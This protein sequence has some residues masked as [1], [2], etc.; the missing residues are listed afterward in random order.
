MK[1]SFEFLWPWFAFKSSASDMK[2]YA[3]GFPT[4]VEYLKHKPSGEWH[5]EVQILGFGF[6][7]ER[8]PTPPKKDV[9]NDATRRLI[10]KI[11]ELKK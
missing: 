1:T 5:F 8:Y 2:Y 3:C 11:G 9:I 6:F 7:I 10:K 4:D